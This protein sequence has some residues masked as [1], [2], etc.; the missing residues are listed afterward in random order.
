MGGRT[1]NTSGKAAAAYLLTLDVCALLC[2]VDWGLRALSSSSSSSSD[3]WGVKRIRH[4]V[5]T[6]CY[7][8]PACLPLSGACVYDMLIAS[9]NDKVFRLGNCYVPGGGEWNSKGIDRG[10]EKAAVSMCVVLMAAGVAAHAETAAY[11]IF[12]P[13]SLT[14]FHLVCN[15]PLSLLSSRTNQRRQVA[16]MVGC[17]LSLN[18][19]LSLVRCVVGRWGPQLESCPAP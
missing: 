16:C 14:I 18:N 6:W 7:H 13:T 8:L 9:W 15:R 5:N 17:H 3:I 10:P 11:Q 19:S 12:S 2:D 1:L 4:A